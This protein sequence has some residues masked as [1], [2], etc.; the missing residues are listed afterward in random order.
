MST[1]HAVLAE[2]YWHSFHGRTKEALE[3]YERAADMVWK[4]RC[5]NSHMILVLPML[6][7]G[8]RLQADATDVEDPKEA[9]RL[10][11]RARKRAKLATRLTWLFP[12]AYPL[13]LRERALILD[14]VGKTKKALRFAEKSCRVAEVQKAKYEHAQ[15][16]LVR[17]RL[18]KM[19]WR[20]E[21]DEQIRIAEAAIEEIEVPVR[22]MASASSVSQSKSL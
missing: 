3:C 2:G 10:R 18:A 15:S 8:L 7:Q 12:A 22:A 5:V 9:R 19:L 14:A 6:V 17:G 1:V 13:A 11:K 4:T 20:P 21:A 16:L